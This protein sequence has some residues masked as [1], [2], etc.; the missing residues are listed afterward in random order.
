MRLRKIGSR[1]VV[2]DLPNFRDHGRTVDGPMLHALGRMVELYGRDRVFP[3][4]GALRRWIAEDTGHMPG[5]TTV[6]KSLQRAREQGL[7]IT[8]WIHRGQILPTG[9]V[10]THGTRQYWLPQ[11]RRERRAAK[12]YNAR[13]D[14]HAGWGARHTPNQARTLLERI[15]KAPPKATAPV[16]GVD[17]HAAERARQNAAALAWI[18]EEERARGKPPPD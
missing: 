14:R 8:H 11:D 4:E 6:Q 12:A 1:E 16:R 2:R 17:P 13:Q 7:V 15:A 3:S 9:E 5:V 18:E 10:A